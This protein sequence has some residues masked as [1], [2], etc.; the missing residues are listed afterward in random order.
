M[1]RLL[2][3]L[4]LVMGIVSVA[5]AQDEPGIKYTDALKLTLIGKI[6]P[7]PQPY[8]RLDTV[9]YHEFNKY[10]N[11][12]V[13]ESA[14]LAFVF[15]TNSS[16][17]YIRTY[18]HWIPGHQNMTTI[19]VAGYDLYIKKNNE[20]LYANSMVNPNNGKTL[21]IMEHM[22]PGEKE[23]LLYLPAFSIV[24]SIAIGVDENS[25]IEGIPNP[26]RHRIVIFGSSF[27]H[28]TCANRPGTS[29]PMIMERKSGLYFM[30]LGVSGNSMLQQSFAKVLADADADAFV[31]DAF[32]NPSAQMIAERFEPFIQ[33][34]RKSHPTTPLIFMQT[35][36]R[37][38]RNFNTE[39]DKE[40]QA[41]MDMG[42][43]VVKKAMLTDKNIYF[44][45]PKNITGDDHETSTDGVHPSQLGYAHWAQTM[46][47]L[48][49]KILAKYGIK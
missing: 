19:N 37:E 7:T 47:P 27:T 12:L 29:Y 8:H 17:L 6:A 4:V 15:K 32:S 30:S 1:K 44:L 2:L 16:R 25:H 5:S 48:I 39:Y 24:D 11:Y 3:S 18:Y 23:C 22:V 21:K 38:R 46:Q 31:F 20:W 13:H 9:K 43:K 35:I 36:Y 34:I 45:N 10:Q 41:K 42:E 33:T 49:V 14:G 28:G 26:F 40:E